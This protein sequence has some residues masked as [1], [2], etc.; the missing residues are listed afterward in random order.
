MSGFRTSSEFNWLWLAEETET[1][2]VL[3]GLLLVDPTI[4]FA[5]FHHKFWVDP[6]FGFAGF[7]HKG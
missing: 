7:Y 5:G 3:A 6:T 1:V 4:R 2:P